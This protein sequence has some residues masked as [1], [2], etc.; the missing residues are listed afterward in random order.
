MTTDEDSPTQRTSGIFWVVSVVA[1]LWNLL[2]LL[3]FV[4]QVTMSD[5]SISALPEDQQEIYRNLP[6]WIYIF[7][8]IAV[9]GGVLGSILLLA[10]TKL[11]IP[12]LA[13]SLLGVVVQYGHMFFMTNTPS[14]MGAAAMVLPVLVVI[15]SIALVP[16]AMNCK[17]QGLLR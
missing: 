6:S 9:F 8:G 15:V 1:L 13:L 7:F 11:A 10:R 4:A 3:A 14:V 16:F 2:G 5:E 17:K 12:V